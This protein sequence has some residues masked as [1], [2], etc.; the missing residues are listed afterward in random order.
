MDVIGWIQWPK[1]IGEIIGAT[2]IYS[3]GGT[4]LYRTAYAGPT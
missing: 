1:I 4:D 3:E 2:R